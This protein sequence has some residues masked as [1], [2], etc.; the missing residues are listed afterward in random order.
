MPKYINSTIAFNSGCFIPLMNSKV[1]GCGLAVSIESRT[2]AQALSMNLWACICWLASL[3]RVTSSKLWLENSLKRICNMV[4]VSGRRKKDTA[5]FHVY[6]VWIRMRYLILK[7]NNFVLK[8]PKW[9]R[10]KAVW[11]C[12]IT[13]IDCIAA[14]NLVLH[15]HSVKTNIIWKV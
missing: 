8:L 6:D 13:E 9:K 3:T 4:A 1:F 7:L 12:E 2:G 15:R 5:F 11:K 14:R 10:A